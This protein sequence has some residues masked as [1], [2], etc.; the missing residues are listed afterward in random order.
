MVT[1]LRYRAL[2]AAGTLGATLLAVWAANLR[3]VQWAATTF[4]PV[5]WRLHPEPLSGSAFGLAALTTLAVVVASLGPL[6]KPRPRRILNV[7]YHVQRRVLIAGLGLA[8]IGYFDY[9]YRLPRPTLIVSMVVLVVGLPWWF[10]LIRR[11]PAGHAERV[12]VVGDDRDEI[13]RVVDALAVEPLG[14]VAPREVAGVQRVVADGGIVV[15]RLGRLTH[16]GGL[17]RLADVL[18]EHDVDTA[19]LAFAEAGR[20]EFFGALGTCREF[21]VGVKVHRDRADGVLVSGGVDEEL[22]EVDLEPWDV[23][24]RLLKRAF[25]VVFAWVGL[26]VLSP[27]ML[28]I[29]VAVKLDSPGPVLYSQQRTAEFGGTF[30]VWKFRS[31]VDGAEDLTG[32]TLSAED[33]GG[34]DPRVTRVGR[35]L[36]R[37]HLDEIPQLWS[38]LVGDMSVVGPRPERPELDGVGVEEAVLEWQQRWFVRPGLTGLAQ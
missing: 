20:G 11:R 34:V 19:V 3:V 30:T 13:E 29:A 1:G 4:V 16:L 22:V 6:F 24:D 18:A 14:Y 35:V 12:V 27:V 7:V 10:V 17:S 36:R 26:V 25:D 28:V 23:Q 32:P 9:T 2:A 5:V 21:G 38:I 8:T 15:G 31:M 33:F 37:T